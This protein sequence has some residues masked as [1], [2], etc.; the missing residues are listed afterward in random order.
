L[1]SRKHREIVFKKVN[2]ESRTF[3][4]CQCPEKLIGGSKNQDSNGFG[5]QLEVL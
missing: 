2:L 1:I 3:S 5:G 4:K